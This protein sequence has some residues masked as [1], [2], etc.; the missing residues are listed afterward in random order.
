MSQI[1][2]TMWEQTFQAF[3]DHDL[4][5]FPAIF[6]HEDQLNALEKELTAYL[7]QI[8]RSSTAASEKAQALIYADIVGD[9][10]L[11]GDYCKDILERVQ[12]KIEEKLL[13]SDDAVEEYVALYER[14]RGAL[15]E[16]V[17]A[18][19][20]D[21]PSKVKDVLK[22][23]EHIDTLVDEYRKRHNERLLA[24]VCSPFACNMFLNML[25]F[26]A[27]VYYHTKKIARNLQKI[28]K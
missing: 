10:E 23:E 14:T 5:L 18:L 28:K 26:T 27:A 25:D 24:G 11:I 9:L 22:K 21:A 13:F 8:G 19:L 3:M 4:D 6:A 15:H 12:I 1:A 7:I 20:A 17:Q 2:L 16:V